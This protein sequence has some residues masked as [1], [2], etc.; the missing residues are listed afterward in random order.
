MDRETFQESLSADGMDEIEPFLPHLLQ[1][2]WALGGCPETAIDL[3]DSAGV[4]PQPDDRVV[5]LGCG[6][7]AMLIQLA[8][9]FGCRGY[10]V[11]LMTEFIDDARKLAR[12]HGVAAR[13]EFNTGDM[14]DAARPASQ[15]GWI[16]YGHDA[17]IFGD[18]GETLHALRHALRPG[19]HLVLDV[20][21][22]KPGA[23]GEESNELPLLAQLPNLFARSG[24][25]ELGRRVFPVEEVRASNKANT[26]AIEKR[27]TELKLKHPDRAQVF[28]DYVQ[29]QRDES[30]MLENDCESLYLL[31]R[32]TKQSL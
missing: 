10:G 25:S 6:K 22:R 20:T 27:A 11:D 4:A 8:K 1:D 16:V 17:P 13:V 14:R 12:E 15:H 28:D 3:L 21:C 26:S 32:A 5:D 7:G 29:N 24:Y 18:L 23:A 2:L 19:G 31:L 9:R 30:A